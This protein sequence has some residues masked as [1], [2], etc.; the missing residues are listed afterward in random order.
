MSRRL[1]DLPGMV[2]FRIDAAAGLVTIA[3]EVDA[4]SAEAAVSEVRRP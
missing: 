1:R 4:G 2:W 3:G